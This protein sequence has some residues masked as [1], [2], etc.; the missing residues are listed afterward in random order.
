[1]NSYNVKVRREKTYLWGSAGITTDFGQ[2]FFLLC[3]VDEFGERITLFTEE[4]TNASP[5]SPFG[6]L[7]PGEA[8]IFPLNKVSGVFAQTITGNVDSLVY[9]TVLIPKVFS[10]I[11]VQT[12]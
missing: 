10:S 9:C 12:A 6:T 8:Y 11:P 1:M 4:K 7:D 2:E 3:R 5:P